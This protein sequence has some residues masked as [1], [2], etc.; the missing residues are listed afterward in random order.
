MPKLQLGKFVEMTDEDFDGFTPDQLK[1]RSCSGY[2][3][4]GLKTYGIYQG[5]VFSMCNQRKQKLKKER[6]DADAVDLEA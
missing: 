3:N 1:C 6:G 4:C 2:G 5:K